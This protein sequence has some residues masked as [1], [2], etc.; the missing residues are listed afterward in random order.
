MPPQPSDEGLAGV[1]KP[2]ALSPREELEESAADLMRV[3]LQLF[4]FSQELAGAMPPPGRE[5]A[6]PAGWHA[7]AS[8]A[9]DLIAAHREALKAYFPPPQ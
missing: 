1:P 6:D 7:A 5:V 8:R 9:E 2:S 3:S 4:R